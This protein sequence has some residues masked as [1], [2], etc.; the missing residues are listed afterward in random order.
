MIDLP[1]FQEIQH[2]MTIQT[3]LLMNC[4]KRHLTGSSGWRTE[5]DMDEVIQCGKNGLDGLANFVKHFVV[6]QGV[7]MGLFEGKLAHLMS[8]LEGK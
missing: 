1:F 5:A 7:S 6:K 2:T 8:K 3:C 4:G